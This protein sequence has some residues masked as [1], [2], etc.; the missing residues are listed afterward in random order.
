MTDTTS[1]ADPT[2]VPLDKLR[3][4]DR[5]HWLDGPPHEQFKRLR[6]QCPVHWT[7]TITEYEDEKGFWSVTT[8]EDI[9]EVSR[10]WETYSSAHGFTGADNIIPVELQSFEIE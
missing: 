7:E 2:D 8:A 9:H 1:A 6:G 4:A 5:E 3:M 10:D